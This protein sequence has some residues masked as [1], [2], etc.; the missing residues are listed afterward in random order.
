MF[1]QGGHLMAN[2]KCSLPEGSFRKQHKGYEEV[3]V[4]AYKPRPFEAGEKLVAITE[5]PEWSR[6]AF[7]G[8][9]TL[10][11]IQSRLC[12]TALNS[13]ENLLLCAPTGAGKTNVALL[14]MLHE[15]GKHRNADGSINKDD[16]KVGIV[17]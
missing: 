3:V 11:R 15:I 17:F 8:F 5:L 6:P 7:Q 9:S 4:P 12:K 14:T 1:S 16:F 10:N 2:K 13:N